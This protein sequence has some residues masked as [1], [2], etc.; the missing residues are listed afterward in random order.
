MGFTKGCTNSFSG[1]R[2]LWAGALA[3]LLATSLLS[4]PA[5]AAKTFYKWVDDEGVTH[6]SERKPM[7]TDAEAV[8][9]SIGRSDPVTNAQTNVQGA[10]GNADGQTAAGSNTEEVDPE[11]LKDPERCNIAR[12]NLETMQNNNRIRMKDPATGEYRFL[13]QQEKEQQM[14]ESQKA[15]DESC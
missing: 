3:L 11:A 14:A 13:S 12:K 5:L 10:Q 7:G 4:L 6:Y 8:S 1:K 2:S 9:V 15:I